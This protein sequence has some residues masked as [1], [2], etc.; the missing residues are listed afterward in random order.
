MNFYR[1]RHRNSIIWPFE[2]FIIQKTKPAPPSCP[3]ASDLEELCESAGREGEGLEAGVVS[4]PVSLALGR[5]PFSSISAA[6]LKAVTM[7]GFDHHAENG[8]ICDAF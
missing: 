6:H 7:S 4:R 8:Y 1:I 2:I 5:G 3:V